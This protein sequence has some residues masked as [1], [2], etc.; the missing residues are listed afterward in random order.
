MNISSVLSDSGLGLCFLLGTHVRKTVGSHTS[1]HWAFIT[2]VLQTQDKRTLACHLAPKEFL[3][4]K[5]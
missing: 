2:N 1:L 4:E 3:E 5:L